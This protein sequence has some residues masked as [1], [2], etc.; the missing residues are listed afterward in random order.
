MPAVAVPVITPA[1]Q[2]DYSITADLGQYPLFPFGGDYTALCFSATDPNT[3]LIGAQVTSIARG[4]VPATVARDAS[5]HITGFSGITGNFA[6]AAPNIDSGLAYGPNGV[7]FATTRPN[8]LLY[9]YK[10]GSFEVDK[11]IDLT[12]LGV[13]PSTGSVA[14]VPAGYP[15]AGGIRFN[16]VWPIGAMYTAEITPD[17]NGTF[18]VSNVTHVM[19]FGGD[20][21]PEQMIWVPPDSPG[22]DNSKQ[23]V[24]V[25][26]YG[27]QRVV[28]YQLDANGHPIFGTH[29]PFITGLVGALGAAIDPLTG[30]FLFSTSAGS[31][32]GDH[33]YVVS[34]S[35]AS[36]GPPGD[37]NNNGRVD[38]ADYVLWRKGG[39]LANEVDTPGTVNAADYTAW[40]SRFGNAAGSSAGTAANTAVPEPSALALL[41]LATAGAWLQRHRVPTVCQNSIFP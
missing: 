2:D 9:Q 27:S 6:Y 1:F 21:G 16:Q 40:R 23:Y 34:R 22:F 4:I 20:N 25:N 11:T 12:A 14:F 3:L 10:P 19:S 24:L 15:G 18:N 17:G 13:Y 32:G 5:G 8:N 38:A 28:S 41:I 7:L 30:D 37:Y 26:H 29:T 31:G 33:I 39:S 36:G 35:A